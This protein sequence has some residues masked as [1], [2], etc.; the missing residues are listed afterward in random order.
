M[1]V[2]TRSTAK[3]S[4]ASN[5]VPMAQPA[6]K[7]SRSLPS[8]PTVLP[9]VESAFTL[10]DLIPASIKASVP[11]DV[12]WATTPLRL[13]V[14]P[15]PTLLTKTA[16]VIEFQNAVVSITVDRSFESIRIYNRSGGIYFRWT[17][18]DLNPTNPAAIPT[19]MSRQS[20]IRYDYDDPSNFQVEENLGW[21]LSSSP[22]FASVDL[23]TTMKM[24]D[25]SGNS[26]Q[27]E[28]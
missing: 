22:L 18:I 17:C 23:L 11:I 5:A 4:T 1:P 7:K 24:L 20:T 2:V 16:Y 12:D 6:E 27:F 13:T 14:S 9:I 10:N 15:P 8:Y 25:M 3:G 26:I 21:C 19:Y 28:L